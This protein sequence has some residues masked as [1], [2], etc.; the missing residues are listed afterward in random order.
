MNRSEFIAGRLR[1]VF[2]NGKLIAFT[3][4]RELISDLTWQQATTKIHDLNSIAALTF[5]VDYYLDG[6]L[7]VMDGGPLEI[8]D[9]YSFDMPEIR[10]ESDWEQLVTRFLANAE[11]FASH[12]HAMPDSK[13]DE[14]FVEEKYGSWY[15][16][17]EVVIEHGYY[18]MGQ[19]A[20]I[21]KM[22]LNNS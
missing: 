16:N 1:E 18:H 8:R 13:M 5:H 2:L 12:V 4:Y 10:S 3:N 20:I 22:V 17:L 6:I 21:K 11:K 19:M 15:R 7:Q 9:K 14:F